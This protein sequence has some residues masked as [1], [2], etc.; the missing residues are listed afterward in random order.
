MGDLSKL[1]TQVR[2]EKNPAKARILQGFFKTGKGEYGEGDVF[3][4]LTVPQSRQLAKKYN[5]LTL[6]EIKKLLRSKVHEERLIALLILVERV[7][8]TSE[9]SSGSSE[10]KRLIFD[11][12]LENTKY[13]NNWDLVDLSADKIVGAYLLGRD[14]SILLRL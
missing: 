6:A 8:N 1:R 2:R 9:V 10:V 14:K 11:F 12:Y 4:G 13:I 5:G 7:Q 3:L